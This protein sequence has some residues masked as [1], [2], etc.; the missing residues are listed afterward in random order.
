MKKVYSYFRKSD[1]LL[2]EILSYSQV[3]LGSLILAV[4]YSFFIVPHHIVPGGI[5]GLSIAIKEL[6][7]GTVGM[8]SLCLNIPILLWGTK[9][10]GTKTGAKT[11]FSMITVA[12]LVDVITYFTEGRILVND[13]LVSSVFGG[14]LI[15]IAVAIVMNSGATTGGND[16]LVR[17]ISKYIKLPFNQLI[18]IVDALIVLVGV[19]VFGDFTMA[20]YCIIAILSISKTIE[21]FLNKNL[22]NKTFLIF[23]NKNKEIEKEILN[24]NGLGNDTIKLMHH[25]SREKMVLITKN[26]KKMGNI[27]DVINR[28]DSKA[29]V[30]ILDSN[31]Y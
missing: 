8:I 10:L 5:F 26:N 11:A 16:I 9:V 25:D 30:I 27:K 6:T 13:V 7:G 28:V 12:M 3:F 18:L 17:I 15:G 19:I 2:T 23:S 31:Q 29:Q 14:V 21:Y 24:S 22:Q 20:A 4:G 1:F